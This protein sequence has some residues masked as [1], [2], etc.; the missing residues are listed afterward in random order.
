MGLETC[1]EDNKKNSINVN[2]RRGLD[3]EDRN[4]IISSYNIYFGN[5]SY[6]AR[7]LGYDPETVRKYWKRAGLYG[8][9][10]IGLYKKEEPVKELSD[11]RI[12]QIDQAFLLYNGN[13]RL[14][15]MNL[16][17]SVPKILNIWRNKG[18]QIRRRG[19]QKGRDFKITE[20]KREHYTKLYETCNGNLDLAT[21][22]SNHTKLTLIK[23][24]KL[25]GLNPIV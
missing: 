4:T 8:S 23:Y 1:L 13:A 22:L 6:A 25:I 3:N 14:A 5:A 20:M 2:G 9:R 24:W 16:K 10:K 17:I 15:S 11:E 7:E 12:D 19:G 18:Y 21:K